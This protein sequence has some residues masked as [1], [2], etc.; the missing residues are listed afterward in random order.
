MSAAPLA[1]SRFRCSVSETSSV[2][3]LQ[4]VSIET[5]LVLT[6]HFDYSGDS[7]PRGDGS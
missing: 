6:Q 7:G 2:I 1:G 3:V 4:L 5:T